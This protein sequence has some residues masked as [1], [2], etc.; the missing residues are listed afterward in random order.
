M[1][2]LT[3]YILPD[4][5][6]K[7]VMEFYHSVFGGELTMT[8]VA[9]SPMKAHFPETLHQRIVNAKLVS[10]AITISASDWLRPKQT[11]IQGNTAC[12]YLS[13][14]SSEEIRDLFDKLSEGADVTDP[15][16]EQPFGTYG[17]LTDK[18]GFRWMFVVEKNPQ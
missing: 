7:Q 1:I 14:D 18:F 16:V 8:T 4:G 17:A 3:T 9:E 11:P 5:T 10:Q 12:F 6:C 15:L 2:T 13:G